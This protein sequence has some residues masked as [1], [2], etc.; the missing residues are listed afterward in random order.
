[1][2]RTKEECTDTQSQQYKL[3]I[4]NSHIASQNLVRL[5]EAALNPDP[6]LCWLS[7]YAARVFY[8]ATGV[9][10]DD[11]ALCGVTTR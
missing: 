4:H 3:H 5:S 7:L 8:G 1:M 10:Q 9:M 2:I 11:E 6:S